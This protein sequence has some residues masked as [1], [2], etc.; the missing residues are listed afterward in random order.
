M[1]NEKCFMH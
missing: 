1:K